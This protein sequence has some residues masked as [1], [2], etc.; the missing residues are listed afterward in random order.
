MGSQPSKYSEA[1]QEEQYCNL[2]FKEEKK[3][4]QLCPEERFVQRRQSIQPT[5]EEFLFWAANLLTLPNRVHE[6]HPNIRV[7]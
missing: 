6:N 7:R 5:V 1:P 3:I 2:L 4:A